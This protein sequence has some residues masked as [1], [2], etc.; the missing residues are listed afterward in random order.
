MNAISSFPFEEFCR[1]NSI[2][3]SKGYGLLR[4]N[5]GPKTFLIGNRRFV[6]ATAEQSWLREMEERP[7]PLTLPASLQKTRAA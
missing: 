3:R 5:L 2:S 4:Q 7:A 1:R 6:S